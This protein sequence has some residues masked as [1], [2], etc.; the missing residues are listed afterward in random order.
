MLFYYFNKM[1]FC[2]RGF[3]K[4]SN[5]VVSVEMCL[6]LVLLS[7]IM[8]YMSGMEGKVIMSFFMWSVETFFVDVSFLFDYISLMFMGV[9]FLISG[10]VG[11]Y[12]NWYM[13]DEV[14]HNRFSM[15]V[16]LFVISMLFFIS[17]SDLLILMVGWDGLGLVSFLLVCYYQTGKSF[18]SA[19]LT[20]LTNRVG[21]VF[22]LLSIGLISMNGGTMFYEMSFISVTNL[23]ILCVVISSMTKSAQFP[24][25][26]W[27]PAAMSAP[28]PVSSLVHSSTLVTAG[29]YI[30]IRS[31][32]LIGFSSGVM[33]FLQIMSLF[34]LAL[35]G[36]AAVLETDFKKVVAL[37]T[38]SQLSMMM[39]SVSI[40]YY[41]IAFFHLVTH[42]LFKALLFLG[43]GVVIHLNKGCQDLRILGKCWSEVPVS[44]SFMVVA[45]SSLC[46][47]PFLS[48][49]Y[50]KHMI[51]EASFSLN[52]SLLSYM[53]VVIGSVFTSWYSFRLFC[54]VFISL[55]SIFVGNIWSNEPL[56]LIVP[57]SFLFLGAVYSGQILMMKFESLKYMIFCT[58][59]VFFV[60]FFI[61]F[62]GVAI[63]LVLC[64][65]KGLKWNSFLMKFFASMLNSK[66]LV[67]NG[68]SYVFMKLC[69]Y[70]DNSVDN[71]W[72]EKSGPDGFYKLFMV[73]SRVNQDIQSFYF[74]KVFFFGAFIMVFSCVLILVLS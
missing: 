19:M 74:L 62:V 53:L 24:F 46:G 1:K 17:L 59:G 70:L 40:G 67:S 32:D 9:V 38:L 52:M 37:S 21:D 33:L 43:A 8:F 35:A 72:L 22:M 14:Y 61:P 48:G 69:G 11:I 28:T 45:M 20:G 73:M 68:L 66:M 64:G 42:A 2:S 16:V 51:I 41:E 25:C 7:F 60:I 49:F 39:F 71:G 56:V 4:S 29:V 55:N 27:L 50:S 12:S 6:F 26:S 36:C 57:M 34:T 47:I 54:S 15:L 44:M 63:F 10:S 5:S 58:E 3:L 65:F 18:S 13:S 30:L 31:S 23:L